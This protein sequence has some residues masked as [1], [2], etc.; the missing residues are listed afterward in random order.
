GNPLVNNIFNPYNFDMDSSYQ[1][2]YVYTGQA[3]QDSASTGIYLPDSFEIDVLPNNGTGNYCITSPDDTILFEILLNPL[4]PIDSSSATFFIGGIQSSIVFAP[5]QMGLPADHNVRYLVYDIYGCPAES[6]DTFS[7]FPIPDLEMTQLN[8]SYCLNE[9]TTQ[10]HL[11]QRET[12]P[13]QTLNELTY[14]GIGYVQFES[15]TLTGAG[16]VNSAGGSLTDPVEPY[17][18]PFIAGVGSHDLAYIYVDS[19]LCADS[20]N[21]TVDIIPLPEV[22][23]STNGG[24][25]LEEFYC[26]NDVVELQGTPVSTTIG[27][28]GYGSDSLDLNG[29]PL[30]NFN[31]PRSLDTTTNPVSFRPFIDGVFPGILQEVLYYYYEDNNGCRDSAFVLVN[32]RNFTTDPEITNLPD[33]TCASDVEITVSGLPSAASV[34]ALSLAAFGWFTTDYSTAFYPLDSSVTF[35]EITTF[36]PDSAGVD[37]AG[38]NVVLTFNYTDTSRSCYNFVTDTVYI[39]PLP[40]LT[41]STSSDQ[42]NLQVPGSLILAPPDTNDIYHYCETNLPVPIHVFD[43]TGIYPQ[44]L[45]QPGGS[46]FFYSP[47]HLTSPVPGSFTLSKGIDS[48]SNAST[49]FDDIRYDFDKAGPGLDTIR[50]TYTNA[51]GCTDSIDHILMID[52]LP[53]LTFAGLNTPVAGTPDTFIYC[54][55]DPDPPLIIPAPLGVFW[56]LNFNAQDIVGV[57]FQLRPD[58]LAVTGVYMNY[59]LDY[60][61][62]GQQY[63]DGGVCSDSLSA[64]IQIRPAPVLNWIDQ[65]SYFCMVDSLERIPISATPYG[66]VLTDATKGVTSGIVA[67]SLFVPSAQPGK[68]DLVYYYFDQGTGCYDT[69]QQSIY[70]Y[71]KPQINFDINGGCSGALVEFTATSPPYGMT[72][73]SLAIDSFTQVIWDFGDGVIDTI[74]N[75]PDTLVIPVDTHTYAGS[76]IFYPKLTVTN[77]GACDTTFIRRIIISPKATPTIAVP[78]EEFFDTPGGWLQEAA[79]TSSIDGVVADSLWEW[80]VAMGSN[81]NTQNSGNLV[82]STRLGILNTPGSATYKQGENAWVYSPC[83]DL[84]NLD[85]PMIE[86]S[87]WRQ[88]L[89]HVDGAVLQYHDNVSNSW[90]VLGETD[91]GINWYKAGFVVSSPGF[92]TGAP[93]GWTGSN[94]T[95]ENARYRLDNVN[96]DLRSRTDVRFR[97]AFASDPF[98]LL[99]VNEGFAFD[100]VRIG[101]RARNV[102][103]EH[104]SGV[105]YN[106]PD[107]PYYSIDNIENHLYNTIYNNLYGRDVSLI[108]YHTDYD[109]ANDFYNFNTVDN[110]A[111][112]FYYGIT[113]NNQ[114]RIDGDTVVGKTSDLLEYPHL[115]FLDIESLKDAKFDLTFQGFPALTITNSTLT[116]TVVIKALQD[117]PAAEYTM[118]V[119][120]TEDSLQTVTSHHTLAVMRDMLPDNAGYRYSQPWALDQTDTVLINWPFNSSAHD[121]SLLGVTIFV[122]NIQTKQVYQVNSSRDIIQ[123]YGPVDSLHYINVDEI[124]DEPGYEIITMK[125]FPNPTENMFNVEFDMELSE[126]HE[127]NLIDPLGRVLQ[128]GIATKG[129]TLMQVSTDKLSTG[130]YIFNMK[131]EKVYSQRRVVVRKF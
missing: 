75:L 72:Y 79:D 124:K 77:Q 56:T 6:L 122:Q 102:L 53:V 26:E 39:N 21:V 100:S 95:W 116:A 104:F 113:E 82:W 16:I 55:T 73:N 44:N 65:F 35:T 17:F 70:V 18:S 5:S 42:L 98:T 11:Y 131:N 62:V 60:Y 84:T 118:Y 10:L 107:S 105:G 88:S 115:E 80:G 41:I 14:T 40:Y 69:I 43:S 83:F 96:S 1:L 51:H 71:T 85:R 101:N 9:D 59:P 25:P 34:P 52:S 108:Q 36:Y 103:V 110:S 20:I 38:R 92:Q 117:L 15:V 130:M 46:I 74:S 54:E 45:F 127:W 87:I 99:G 19:N 76:G 123:F 49:G 89:N 12:N 125:L 33:T 7:V 13:P 121:V 47:T 109:G 4:H 8:V 63:A 93:I 68:R 61:Y 86:L 91:K 128:S 31:V 119:V 114:V 32:I 66:G 48:V 37:Y 94:S 106:L 81:I 23:L 24:A 67:D 27:K 90:K 22:S 112:I 111:R 30:A 97:I 120:I 29:L 126:D 50:Y 28:F 78:Y 2:T 64:I 3:C 57:P 58:T 129:T